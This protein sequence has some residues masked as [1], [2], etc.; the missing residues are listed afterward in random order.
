M[1]VSEIVW[2]RDERYWRYNSLNL[3]IFGSSIQTPVTI[4]KFDLNVFL[5]NV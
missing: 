4:H 2:L 5:L 1:V 3:I